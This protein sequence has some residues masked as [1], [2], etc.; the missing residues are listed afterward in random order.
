MDMK[1]M[2]SK[3][4]LVNGLIIAVI[5]LLSGGVGF[6]VG[7]FVIGEYNPPWKHYEL[8]SAPPNLVNI[9]FIE[10]KSTLFDPTGDI[11]YVSDKDGI[12]YSN[13]T[14][15][16]EWLVVEPIPTWENN[17]LIDC[18]SERLGPN[19][20]HIW[21]NPPVKRTVIDSAGVIYDR[22]LSTIVRCYV[23]LDDGSI[24]VWVHS[25]D[26]LRYLA[27]DFFKKVFPLFGSILGVIIYVI[28]KRNR[29]K[30]ASHSDMETKEI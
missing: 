5:I 11:V 4:R 24:E 13:T 15:Q 6:L 27:F 3:T 8:E 17:Y 30:A 28:V 7:N 18:I 25:D 22:P 16:T 26:F 20:A 14:F 21:D 1:K 2:K 10:I 23:L 9:E 29:K 19:K 12:V